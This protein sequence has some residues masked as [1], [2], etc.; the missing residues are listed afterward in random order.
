MTFHSDLFAQKVSR[1][2][3]PKWVVTTPWLI[4]N[5]GIE[6]TQKLFD[7]VPYKFGWD[8]LTRFP[9]WNVVLTARRAVAVRCTGCGI[10]DQIVK[11]FYCRALMIIVFSCHG[12]EGCKQRGKEKPECCLLAL[13]WLTWFSKIICLYESIHNF[14]FIIGNVNHYFTKGLLG[15]YHCDI[16]YLNLSIVFNVSIV[17][18]QQKHRRQIN[19][20]K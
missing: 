10:K 12:T 14:C 15:F 7:Q 20:F 19:D 13:A 16:Q 17:C 8:W 9:L 3:V 4:R 1:P 6:R 18:I 11:C 2:D 5:R